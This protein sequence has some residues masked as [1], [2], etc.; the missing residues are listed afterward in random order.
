LGA[1]LAA[2]I[3]AKIPQLGGFESV[4]DAKASKTA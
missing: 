2:P 4:D 3:W 1:M